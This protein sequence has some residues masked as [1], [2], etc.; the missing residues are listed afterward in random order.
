MKNKIISIV[1]VIL[2]ITI[3]TILFTNSSNS[4]PLVIGA[5]LPLTG[6]AQF[7]GEEMKKGMDLANQDTKINLVY[8]DSQSNTNSAISAYQKLKSQNN[9]GS[10]ILSLSSVANAVV[11]IAEKDG[12]FSMQTLVSARKAQGD[13]SIRYFTSAEQE[14]PIMANFA[15]KSLN[16]K[17]ISF[18]VSN[19]EYG[20]T[21]G[22]VF[23]DVAEKSG[24]SIVDI[25]EFDKKDQ[26]FKT[27]ITKIKNSE[28]EGVYIIG[29]DNQ[30]VSILKQM[31][32]MNFDKVK[33]TNW[34]LSSQTVQEKAGNLAE[35]VYLTTPEY[36][37]SGNQKV[38]DFSAAYEN[39][40]K[41][42]PSAYSAIGYDL[43]GIYSQS[44]KGANNS[45]EVFNNLK[46]VKDFDGLMGKLNVN[47]KGEINFPL[48]PAKIE[49]GVMMLIK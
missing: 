27:Q 16:L 18:L 45:K 5:V 14:A 46:N 19:D 6:P 42:K 4:K 24:A 21:Y 30:L 15:T 43:T 7:F 36:Y 44:L 2:V 48:F 40:Y 34:I 9:L 3:G 26:D 25:E 38:M 37:L 22:E 41:T 10:V 12:I 11:P 32:E 39:K 8:E 28:A 49:N 20:K 29:L 31:K 17:K 1:A 35:G 23:K 33:M 13:L 47:E